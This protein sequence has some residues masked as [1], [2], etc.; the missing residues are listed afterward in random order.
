MGAHK[1]KVVS[2]RI[3]AQKYIEIYQDALNQ[4][5][6]INAYILASLDQV[7][8]LEDDN[9]KICLEL[10]EHQ[11]QIKKLKKDV[12]SAQNKKPKEIIKEIVKVD[13]IAIKK[14]NKDIARLKSNHSKVVKDLKAEI[15]VERER[16]KYF[17]DNLERAN[18]QNKSNAE[19]I[20]K[21]SSNLQKY[22]DFLNSL[23]LWQYKDGYS[24]EKRILETGKK[25]E[26]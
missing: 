25:V 7:N 26:F 22:K 24:T 20:T 16:K 13:E 21:L 6:S 11:E 1:S 23:N 10:K 3:D 9:K 5:K 12:L 17:E 8:K 15:K 18:E 14:L 19:V 4:E 2:I